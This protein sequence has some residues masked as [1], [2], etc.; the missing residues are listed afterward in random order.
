M[1]QDDAGTRGIMHGGCIWPGVAAL[2]PQPPVFWGNVLFGHLAMSSYCTMF[3][4]WYFWA[5]LV[6]SVYTQHSG[7]FF[8]GF[9]ST[10][11]HVGL[12]AQYARQS[13]VIR[14]LAVFTPP[15]ECVPLRITQPFWHAVTLVGGHLFDN[16]YW[17]IFESE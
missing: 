15:I 10:P 8:D 11:M 16:W 1:S 3:P 9:V 12:A 14:G 4:S 7:G 6:A 2:P 17:L 5:S 13:K